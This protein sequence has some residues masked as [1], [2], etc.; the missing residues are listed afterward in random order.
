MKSAA[1]WKRC[2]AELKAGLAKKDLDMCASLH[3]VAEAGL[4]KLL[5]P[6]TYVMHYTRD[7]LADRIETALQTAA[8]E[9]GEV[10]YEVGS[11][12]PEPGPGPATAERASAQP[13]SLDPSFT[14]DTHVEGSSNSIA[15]AAAIQAGN[16]AGKQKSNGYNINPLFIYGG[17]GLGKTHLMQA[18]GNRMLAE[19]P[20]AKVAYV[21]SETFVSG[22]VDALKNSTI[23]EF[24]TS[25]RS[26]DALLIDDIQFFASKTRSQEEF[27]H[28]FS[29]LLD[30]QRQII[31]TSDRIPKEIKDTDERLISRFGSGLMV[32]VQ[33]PE[34]ETRV[35]ILQN[36][37]ARHGITLEDEVAF[38]VARLVISNVRELEGALNQLIAHAGFTRRAIDVA[39]ARETLHAQISHRDRQITVGNIQKEVANYYQIRIADMMSSRR[40]RNIARPRQM[41]MALAKELTNQSLPAI[42]DQFGG[43]DHTTVLHACR[44]I[45][46][47]VR[48][49]AALADDYDN[50]RKKI[51]G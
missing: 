21:R 16:S 2:L 34:L 35:A 27:F 24:K 23:N 13:G 19:N 12:A 51:G 28:T 5:A 11:L 3:P 41:A 50:L 33:P 44:K 26:L 40:T 10:R 15:R 7:N 18:A 29:A 17:V 30:R 36:K 43:R 8:P 25:Y 37:A 4:L 45:G 6:N 49:D 9:I 31:I 14:F 47:L 32:E 42:A 39:L 48:E 20:R 46:Q 22:M 38:Y 1:L